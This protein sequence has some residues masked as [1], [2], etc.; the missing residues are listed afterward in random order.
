MLNGATRRQRPVAPPRR[1]STTELGKEF[2]GHEHIQT[3]L[4]VP[5]YV[6]DPYVSWQRATE[7][8]PELENRTRGLHRG[9][10]A[11]NLTNNG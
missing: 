9:S 7:K 3:L 11:L 1:S 8:V 4:G 2:N 10:V 6:A 5:M